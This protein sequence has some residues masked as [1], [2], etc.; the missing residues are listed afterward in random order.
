MGLSVHVWYCLYNVVG[1]DLYDES[2]SSKHSPLYTTSV[3][4]AS[5]WRLLQIAYQVSPSE[6]VQRHENL[7]TRDRICMESS[8]TIH[9]PSAGTNLN[10]GSQYKDEKIS[11]RLDSLDGKRLATDADVKQAVTSQLRTLETDFLYAEVH[12]IV[13]C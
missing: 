7:R 11:T 3:E 1:R 2:C 8:P 9:K 13:P 4:L 10:S 5:C 6:G 12:A